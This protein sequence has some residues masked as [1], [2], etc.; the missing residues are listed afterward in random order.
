MERVMQARQEAIAVKE[1]KYNVRRGVAVPKTELHPNPWNPRSIKPRALEAL[2]E[3]VEEFGQI[4]GLVVRPH[5]DREGEY[6]IIDGESRHGLLPEVVYCDVID[7]LTDAQAKKLTLIFK[8][9]RGTSDK[10]GLSQLLSDLEE[11]FGTMEELMMGLPYRMAELEEL[12][13]VGKFDWETFDNP[14]DLLDPTVSQG[15]GGSDFKRVTFKVDA[16][17]VG[18][19]ESFYQLV[20]QEIGDLDRNR[21]VA[22]GQVVMHVAERFV[23]G[24]LI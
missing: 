6:Q 5:P 8:E 2:G 4:T 3:A 14:P 11:E 13:E 20:E 17:D 1:G 22:W 18:K 7:G 9:T 10:V 12:I 16:A 21:E 15:G 23:D 24:D 19:L